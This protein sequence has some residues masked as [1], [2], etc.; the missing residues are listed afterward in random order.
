MEHNKRTD[1]SE[2][3][4]S[5]EHLR[6][7][8]AK[9]YAIKTNKEY[10]AAIKEVSEGK[11]MNREREDR[12]LA[13]MERIE[14][15]SKE[16]TQL[17]SECAEKEGALTAGREAVQAEEE[18]ILARIKTESAR[19]PELLRRIEKDVLRKYDT[20]R[21]RHAQ[22]M[23]GVTQGIC[24]GC[25]TRVPPQLYNEMLRRESFKVCPSCQ[26]LLYVVAASA[27]AE[28]GEEKK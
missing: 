19:R 3:A 26:R 20:V 5:V 8:E 6:E 21:S 2:L 7:R 14:A 1:E 27:E 15:L 9:L 23:A 24:Q 25:S 17:E 13:A 18:A 16:I 12:I 28:E 22:A 4:A 10:Q 11:R